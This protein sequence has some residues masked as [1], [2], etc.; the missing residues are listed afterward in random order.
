M[1]KGGAVALNFGFNE[2]QGA[3]SEVQTLKLRN[4]GNTPATYNLSALWNSDPLGAEVTVSPSNVSV[5]PHSRKAID[6][7][8][9]ISRQAV[10]ALPMA[11]QGSDTVVTLRGQVVATPTTD[12]QPLSI[13]FM[14]APH[15]RSDI[16]VSSASCA[17]AVTAPL[18]HGPAEQ[19]GCPRRQRRRLRLVAQRQPGP[20]RRGRQSCC[21][22][23]VLPRHRPRGRHR[24]PLMV[25]AFSQFDRSR[26]R[27]RTTTTCRSTPIA[28]TWSTTRSSSSTAAC[29]RPR[30]ARRHHE[31]YVLDEDFN[32]FVNG[33]DVATDGSVALGFAFPSDLGM[34][35]DSGPA[36]LV[37]DI[38]SLTTGS[39]DPFEGAATINPFRPPASS[40]DFLVMPAGS[41]DSF[42]IDVRAPRRNEVPVKGWMV[43]TFDDESGAPQSD[44]VPA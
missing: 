33:A 28:T 29:S 22:R 21:R 40:G 41:S 42:T 31:T 1:T 25:F 8:L 26:L 34:S 16:E 3:Y 5:P 38:S 11:D 32:G 36:A 19:L 6:V 39:I 12:H 17:T 20:A 4:T 15:G 27:R 9:S 30:C 43:V 13:A 2:S 44:L 24:E 37:A 14:M 35:A 10:A 18:R 23:A 7:R